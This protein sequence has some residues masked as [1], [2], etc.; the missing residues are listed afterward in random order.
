MKALRFNGSLWCN[1][2]VALRNLDRIYAKV[3]EPLG[4]SVIEWYVL[5]ALAEK[6][7]QRASDLAQIVGRLPASF[8]PILDNLERR[9]LIVRRSDPRDRRAIRIHLTT[10]GKS[11]R[12]KV[13]TSAAE[14]DARVQAQAEND[15]EWAAFLRVLAGLQNVGK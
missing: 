5:R 2:D 14:I 15:E 7:G 4:V 3:T 12:A 13:R 1:L 6:D 10:K 8:T 9:K 11:L